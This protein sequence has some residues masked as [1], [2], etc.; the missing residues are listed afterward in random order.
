MG[1]NLFEFW[2]AFVGL[3]CDI[4]ALEPNDVDK[5]HPGMKYV[6]WLCLIRTLL[7]LGNQF[8]KTSSALTD[9]PLVTVDEFVG[10]NLSDEQMSICERLE[11]T[12]KTI[13]DTGTGPKIP[14]LSKLGAGKKAEDDNDASK[15]IPGE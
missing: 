6:M 3:K 11:D 14:G 13:K 15:K 12:F 7:N 9:I 10:F 4:S 1:N 8:L 5:T 2:K